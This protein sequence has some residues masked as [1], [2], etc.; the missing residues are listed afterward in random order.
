MG[1]NLVIFSDCCW[2]PTEYRSKKRRVPSNVSLAQICLTPASQDSIEQI[3]FPDIASSPASKFRQLA[4]RLFGAGLRT[5]IL[6]AYTFLVN[7]YL[8]GDKIFFVGAGLGA[9]NLRRLAD[10]IDRVG[11]LEPENINDLAEVFEYSQI[12]IEALDTPAAQMIFEKLKGRRIS[13][14]FLGCWDTIGSYG[15]PTPGLNRISQ[16]W[17]MLHDHKINRNVKAAYQALALDEPRRRFQPGL[18]TGSQ[19]PDKQIV[20]QVWFC[21]SHE[22]IVGGLRDSGLSDIALIWLLQRAEEHGLGIDHEK[23]EE[24]T[25]ADPKGKVSKTKWSYFATPLALRGARYRPVGQTSLGFAENAVSAAEKLHE[26]VLTR[27]QVVKNYAPHQLASL[28]DG[29]I[30]VFAE[31]TKDIENRRQHERIFGD[32]AATLVNDDTQISVSLVDYSRSGARIWVAG[33]PPTGA[34]FILKSSMKFLDNVKSHVVWAKDGY[35]GLKFAAPLK[36]EQV[37]A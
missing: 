10:M 19:S 34:S 26:T 15:L 28:P 3:S 14:D 5:E 1:R 7:N 23:L 21:G 8:P 37:T 4:R 24:N 29:A 27:Q 33:T 9:F 20:E 30:P 12:P 25:A 22:N 2:Q 36:A 6:D 18:W 11:L 16:S 31:K 35:L 17:M 32:W 13:I